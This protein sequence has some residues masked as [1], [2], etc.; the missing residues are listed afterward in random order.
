MAD[1]A[2]RVYQSLL[3]LRCQ[4]GDHAAFAEL[5]GLYQSGLRYF[6]RKMVGETPSTDDLLQDVWLE[7]FKGI[8]KLIDPGAFP[9]WL[10]QVA[11][12]R[13]LCALRKQRQ[14]LQR[15]EGIDPPGKDE[16]EVDFCAEEAEKVHAALGQL[17][18]DQR[19][20]L[21][22]RFVEDMS[23]EDIARVIGC[24]LGTVRS[25]IHYAKVALRRVL[26]RMGGHE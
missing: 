17:K 2:E 11:R 25:R 16:G 22:L 9:T 21:L 24:Q 6:L 5:V 7:V 13:A 18:P 10:Y 12:H 14:L 19:E 23:Y 3:V 4:A 26:E 8:S 20:V 15:L 1:K